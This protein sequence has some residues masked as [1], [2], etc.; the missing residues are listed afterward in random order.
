MT[1][2]EEA[3]QPMTTREELMA[4]ADR[5]ANAPTGWLPIDGEVTNITFLPSEVALIV[6]ALRLASRQEVSVEELA[7]S[8]RARSALNP[9]ADARALLA[10]YSITKREE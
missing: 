10:E 3:K 4:I 6:N 7:Q 5:I 8:L 1:S 9:N 2:R